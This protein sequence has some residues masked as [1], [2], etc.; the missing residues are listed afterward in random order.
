MKGRRAVLILKVLILCSCLTI[1]VAGSAREAGTVALLDVPTPSIVE[2]PSHTVGT[3]NV[4]FWTPVVNPDLTAYRIQA[5]LSP[6]F[7]TVWRTQVVPSD[8]DSTTFTGLPL[9][10][11]WYRVQA[12]YTPAAD[13]FWSEWSSSVFSIQDIAA[14]TTDCD[15]DPAGE[16]S[17][18]DSFTFSY[19]VEDPAGIDSVFLY[20]RIGDSG[21]WV[22]FDSLKPAVMPN[23]DGNVE[24]SSSADLQG[25]SHYQFFVGGR[26]NARASNWRDGDTESFGNIVR[27]DGSPAMCEIKIDTRLPLSE[28][29]ASFEN[30]SLHTSLNFDIPYWARDTNTATGF[31]SGLDTVYLYWGVD[32]GAINP[33]VPRENIAFDNV[34]IL[35]TPAGADDVSGSYT[36]V[37]PYDTSIYYFY[38]I[39][40]DVAGNRQVDDTIYCT[41]VFTIL[42]ATLTL[43][44]T[45]DT[46]DSEYTDLC[47]VRAV[48]DFNVPAVDSLMLCEDS[49]FTHHC[50]VKNSQSTRPY[51]T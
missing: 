39:A 16:W 37:A 5:S 29:D 4:V 44:D 13:T 27:A 41:R 45:V 12:A 30:D 14:P 34:V 28:I 17:T 36:F 21:P 26:D 23:V 33:T 6:S 3:S 25:D 32:S 2:E 22:M 43:F 11:M 40:V 15:L 20:R 7:N 10:T 47:V 35:Q 24:F 1:A 31:V 18:L 51:T 46:I 9:D 49:L 50:P 19:L 42:E 48:V 38:T 8:W